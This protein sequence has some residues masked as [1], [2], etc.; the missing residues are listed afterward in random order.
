M[1][2]RSDYG[3]EDRLMKALVGRSSVR[4]PEPYGDGK[5]GWSWCCDAKGMRVTAG[6]SGTRPPGGRSGASPI[7]F[8]HIGE[9]KRET[10]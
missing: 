10:H 5:G 4:L 3:P 1:P 7:C 6:G 9:E 2:Q 8:G